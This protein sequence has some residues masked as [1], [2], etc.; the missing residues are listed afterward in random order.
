[1]MTDKAREER[2]QYMREYRKRNREKIKDINNRYWEKKANPN[3][4]N[5]SEVK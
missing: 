3:H 2:N 5:K 4:S 1:M